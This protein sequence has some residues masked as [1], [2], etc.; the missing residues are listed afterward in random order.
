MQI[1][2]ISSF[3][4]MLYTENDTIQLD[5][6]SVVLQINNYRGQIQWQLSNNGIDWSNLPGEESDRLKFPVFGGEG[7]YRASI[8]E[9]SCAPVF[10]EMAELV[11]EIPSVITDTVTSVTFN[12]A[13]LNGEVTNDGGA[14][15]TSRGFYWSK[16]NN[17]PGSGDNVEN[18]GSGTG[19]FSASL[20]GLE[21]NTTYYVRSF[22]TNSEGTSTG[23]VISFKTISGDLPKDPG[24]IP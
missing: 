19:T 9:G 15:V 17:N 23:E 14:S 24:W 3:G 10:S 8:V 20:S 2:S 18:S 12:S 22:A 7:Y 5:Q 13:T 1:F 21:A 16:T 6:D 11:Y 4:Q